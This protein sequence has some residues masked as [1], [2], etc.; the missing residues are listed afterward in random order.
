[1]RLTFLLLFLSLAACAFAQSPSQ[2]ET[3]CTFADG[4]Q[5]TLRYPQIPHAKSD[6]PDGNP[7]PA[8]NQPIY[9]FSQ[10]D[11]TIGNI[12]VPAGAYG[13]YTVPGKKDSWD[14]VVTRDV[15]QDGNY[16]SAQDLGRVSMQT[17]QLPT[18]ASKLTAYFGHVAP[19]TCAL[20][21]DYGKERG[22]TDF[23]EK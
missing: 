2:G 12:N 3:T 1:M 21:L 4:K 5:V 11:L 13:V 7:W 18:P 6:L 16:D 9:L 20:R 22:Y 19:Q 23:K 17:G 8:D 14:L 15:K 10:A